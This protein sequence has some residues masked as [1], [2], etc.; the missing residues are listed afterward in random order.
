[1]DSIEDSSSQIEDVIDK[2]LRGLEDKKSA[3]KA[4][5]REAHSLKGTGGS[6]GY[7]MISSISHRLEDFLA[8]E[9][10]LSAEV[11]HE[12]GVFLDRIR[13]IARHGKEPSGEEA[14]KL[15]RALPSRRPPPD[16]SVN[17]V[18]V[19]VLLGVPSTVTAKI[20]RDILQNCGFRVVQ[21]TRL[22]D[23]FTV[24]YRSKPNA[25][26]FSQTLDEL[27]GADLARALGAMTATESIPAAV[28]TS[29]KLDHTALKSL[30]DSVSIIRLGKE[31]FDADMGNFLSRIDIKTS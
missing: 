31:H 10:E 22:L 19:E 23:C 14:T 6:Y 12:I 18:D 27:S 28:L 2:A 30:P 16:I 11:S 15:L 1:M 24:T 5:R 20:V 17:V 4:I 26:I 29:F 3:L 8:D 21:A 13:E 7:P 25:V 9:K